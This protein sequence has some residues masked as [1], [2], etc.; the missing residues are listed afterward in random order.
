LLKRNDKKQPAIVNKPNA[1]I[2]PQKR[3]KKTTIAIE[4][5]RN[6]KTLP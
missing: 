2:L 4:K 3:G 6:N 5:N 1:Q